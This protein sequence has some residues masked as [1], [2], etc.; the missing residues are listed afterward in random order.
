MLAGFIWTVGHL[1]P[2]AIKGRDAMALTCAVL[3]G[4]LTLVAWLVIGVTVR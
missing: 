4:V 2:N 3:T 1:L